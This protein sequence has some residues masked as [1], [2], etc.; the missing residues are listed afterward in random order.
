M[1]HPKNATFAKA[2]PIVVVGPGR[3]GTSAAAGLLHHL[4]VFMG[5]E[6]FPP[7]ET[8]PYGH[9]EDLDFLKPNRHFLAKRWNLED[10]QGAVSQAIA[11]RVALNTTWG[12]KDPRSSRLI[13]RYL[14]LI[15]NARFLRCTRCRDAIVSSFLRAYGE[16]GWTSRRA[17]KF[18]EKCERILDEHLPAE[19]TFVVEFEAIKMDRRKWI[20][21]IV[22]FF[23][24][25]PFTAQQLNS[26]VNFVRVD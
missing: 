26:A 4:G 25:G 8:N 2:S 24:L 9:W 21:A 11:V 5:K 3:C 22:V 20:D 12:W 14:E 19:R 18:V 17:W 6:F 10:W 1:Q 13:P 23:G 15:P 7:Q 16:F